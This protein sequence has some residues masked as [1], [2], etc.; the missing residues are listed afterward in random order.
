MANGLYAAIAQG[1]APIQIQDPLNQMA[2]VMAIKNAQQEGQLNA[3]RMAEA[4]AGAE[5]TGRLRN[6]LSQ[7]K[8]L[9]SPEAQAAIMG[10]GLKGLEYAKGLTAARKGGLEVKELEGKIS[11]QQEDRSRARLTDLFNN[12]SDENIIAHLQD[13]LNAGLITRDKAAQQ[14][15]RYS[16]MTPDQ[17]K[18][19]F[20]T[21]S[22]GLTRYAELNKPQFITQESGGETRVLA[23]PGMGGVAAEVQGSRKA[24]TL[25]PEQA[26]VV[27]QE[28]S[29]VDRTITDEAGNVTM[30]NKFG[31]VITPTAGGAP[32]QVKAKPSATFEKSR[33]MRVQLNKD[34]D[35]AITELT[36]ASKDGGLIDQST[37]SGAGRAVDIAA[38]FFGQATPGAI[39]ISKL[40]PIADIA[41]KMVPRFEGPQSDKDTQSYKEAAGQL[42]NP[43][44]PTEIRKQA[45]REIVRLMKERKNQFVSQDMATEGMA[46][47]AGAAPT[48]TPIFARNPQT[49]QRI[50][51]TD[52]GATWNP[53]R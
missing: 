28:R 24:K 51:S 50:M 45:A 16:A 53:A 29:V 11:K 47:S 20:Q 48:V 19:E 30:L 6:V 32:A 35:R 44:L 31:E 43:N 17:R 1:G 34:L 25:T 4:Q 14:L 49:G 40:Q 18:Q 10:T 37:G 22:L 42:A 5:E 23:I 33:E 38:G 52:G 15:A 13:D 7:F 36:S 39:A 46:P 27:A 21:L 12:P 9:Y 2:R 3:L 26:R 41:L 8:D